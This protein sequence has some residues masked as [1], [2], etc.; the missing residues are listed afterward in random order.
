MR[1]DPQQRVASGVA[2]GVVQ[3]RA[4]KRAMAGALAQAPVHRVCAW[5]IRDTAHLR[6]C[7]GCVLL[8]VQRDVQ[9]RI[10]ALFAVRGVAVR[11]LLCTASS[12]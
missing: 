3:A 10:P 8:R 9:K 4:W 6:E 5:N 1:G 11:G 7:D 2:F 12:E